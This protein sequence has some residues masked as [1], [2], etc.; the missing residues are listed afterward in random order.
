MSLESDRSKGKRTA[1]SGCSGVVRSWKAI[2]AWGLPGLLLLALVSGCGFRLRGQTELPP[3]M[4]ITYIKVNRPP[5]TPPG[6]LERTLQN[7]LKA[8]GTEVATDP[9][10]ATAILEIVNQDKS[11]RLVATNREGNTRIWTLT[12]LV[13]YR[14]LLPDNKVLL[15][16]TA[17]SVSRNVTYPESAVLSRGQGE[18]ITYRDMEYELV[19]AIFFRLEALGRTG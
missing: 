11:S 17:A 8:N 4:R 13:N 1:V 18:D 9:K 2:L 10:Q 6:T 7:F 16:Q 14:V 15:P 12:Y 19:R 3:A 5:G